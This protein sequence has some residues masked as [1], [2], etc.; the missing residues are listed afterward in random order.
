MENYD[1]L[2]LQTRSS[3][4]EQIVYGPYWSNFML[5]RC[6]HALVHTL[7]YGCLLIQPCSI[8]HSVFCYKRYNLL[9]LN[10]RNK[11]H[12]G[13]LICRCASVT[14]VVS[15]SLKVQCAMTS[16]SCHILL[17]QSVTIFQNSFLYFSVR[18]IKLCSLQFILSFFGSLHEFRCLVPCV[19]FCAF[20]SV[21]C[22][23]FHLY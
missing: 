16:F 18:L 14:A 13:A 3:L 5:P 9:N 2:A 19:I 10:K 22:Y 17:D 1:V 23:L 12:T 6:W 15:A 20:V 11:G 7:Q 8:V 21:S 4:R